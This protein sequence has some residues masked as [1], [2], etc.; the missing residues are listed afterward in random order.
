L[1]EE[2]QPIPGE[3]F[4]F[5]DFSGEPQC[6]LSEQQLVGE[7]SQVGFAPDPAVPLLELNRPASNVLQVGRVPVIY[8][9]AFRYAN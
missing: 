8:Q 1:R 2:S 9:G 6:F 7:L 3:S 4:V 5:T